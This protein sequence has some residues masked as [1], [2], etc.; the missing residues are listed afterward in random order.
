MPE[1]HQGFAVV[2][3]V[4]EEGRPRVLRRNDR[5]GSQGVLSGFSWV[6]M[7]THGYSWVLS[8]YSWVLMG[9][10]WVLR[11]CIFGFSGGSQAGTTPRFT[12]SLQLHHGTSIEIDSS[13]ILSQA[14][15]DE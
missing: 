9:S 11:L 3:V 15:S 10:Q 12:F 2:L 13:A 4:A 5:L 8:G 14:N 1:I 7:G 6:L